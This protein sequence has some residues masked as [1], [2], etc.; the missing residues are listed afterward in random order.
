MD[1]L[2]VVL[3]IVIAIIWVVYNNYK[4]ISDASKKRD[5][6]K[7]PAEVIQENWPG[8][9]EKPVVR[10]KSEYKPKSDKKFSGKRKDKKEERPERPKMIQSGPKPKLEDS[11]FAIL[12]QLKVRKDA[13]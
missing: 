9:K 12:E 2:K 10:E 8:K 3:Y 7:P 4:K 11:P 1:D 6:S 5:Y 13:S